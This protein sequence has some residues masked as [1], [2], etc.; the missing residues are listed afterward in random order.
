MRGSFPKHN[1]NNNNNFVASS[2]SS[3]I[4]ESFAPSFEDNH[5]QQENPFKYSKDFMLSLYKPD[6]QL[7]SDF[8]QHEYVTTEDRTCPLAFEELTESEKKVKFA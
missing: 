5:H 3:D 1:T 4:L 2:S 7:P 8:K 6:F